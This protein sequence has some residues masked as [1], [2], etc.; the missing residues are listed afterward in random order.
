MLVLRKQFEYQL[1]GPMQI[2]RLAREHHPP[3]GTLSFTEERPDVLGHEAR[4]VESIGH[5]G[6][7]RFG[8][9]VVTVIERNG[10]AALQIQHG[11]HVGRNRRAGP[12]EID[13]GIRRA[14]PCR[15]RRGATTR[16]V[17]IERI[18]R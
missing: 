15:F 16:D 13:R 8:A 9:D 14:K 12:L 7:E 2:A 6:V 4:N 10:T 3:K 11:R 18:V 1:V 5:A 17:A